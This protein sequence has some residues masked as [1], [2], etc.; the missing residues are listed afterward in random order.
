M[1]EARTGKVSADEIPPLSRNR[2]YNVLWIGNL[3]S[4]LGTEIAL[5]GF[6]LLILSTSGSPLE[7]ALVSSVVGAAAI[8]ANIPAG[9]LADRW[10]RKKILL[11]CQAVRAAGIASLAVALALDHYVFWHVLVVAA[12]EG[13][14]GAMFEPTEDAAMAQVVPPEQL[15]VAIARNTVRPYA[16]TLV[17]PVLAGVLFGLGHALPFLA[18]AAMLVVSFA[19]L[20]FLAL[21]RRAPAADGAA[22]GEDR[23]DEPNGVVTDFL[24]GLRWV[25]GHRVI[26]ATLVWLV[27]SQLV[28][29]ALIIIILVASGEENV[30]PGEIGLTMSC[31]GAGGVL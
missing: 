13:L 3:L 16:A 12:I 19:G 30:S 31:L 26:R 20:L 23:P 28:F 21:P 11:A 8:L 17:G 4:Q 29:G 1:T 2:N 24:T 6:P 10:N 7:M 15:S 5:I 22:D 9:V 27:V 18:N 25:F 14:L